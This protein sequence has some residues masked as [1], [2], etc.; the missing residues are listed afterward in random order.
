MTMTLKRYIVFVAGD[1]Y[2]PKGGWS[3]FRNDF[4][5]EIHAIGYAQGLVSNNGLTWAQV[6]D[7]KTLTV[8]Y[9]EC[10]A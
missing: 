1:D 4:D 5:N 9:F 10:E 6:V 2:Y 7:L 8:K 3:D